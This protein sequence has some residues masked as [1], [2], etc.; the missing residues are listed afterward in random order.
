[1]KTP[2][3]IAQSPRW[4]AITTELESAEKTGEPEM[5]D[6]EEN[7]GDPRL[8]KTRNYHHSGTMSSRRPHRSRTV[9]KKR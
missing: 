3:K 4:N 8:R 7:T 1:M 2:R 5:V 9:K 6:H